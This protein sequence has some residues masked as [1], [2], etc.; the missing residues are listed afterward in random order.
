MTAAAAVGHVGVASPRGRP[1]LTA[2]AFPKQCVRGEPV[3]QLIAAPPRMHGEPIDRRSTA[4]GTVCAA[5][6][7]RGTLDRFDFSSVRSVSTPA[8]AG[9]PRS[10]PAQNPLRRSTPAC[11]GT[12]G[13]FSVSHPAQLSEPVAGVAAVGTVRH[14]CQAIACGSGYAQAVHSTIQRGG[15]LLATRPTTDPSDGHSWSLR[16]PSS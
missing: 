16:R 10:H 8:C 11:A 7:A 12:P 1:A 15:A 3:S 4:I 2:A 13:D 9:T 6:Y 5:P 14:P